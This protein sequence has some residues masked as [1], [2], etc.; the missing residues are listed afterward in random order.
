[1]IYILTGNDSKSKGSQIKLL[2]K[3]QKVI[4]LPLS[5][6]KEN[7]LIYTSFNLFNENPTIVVENVLQE[8]AF[9]FSD[10]ELQSLKESPTNFIFLEDSLNKEGEK[11]YSK[12]AE[13][14]KKFEQKNLKSTPKENLF[15]IVD[16]FAKKNKIETWVLYT[17][18]V[19]SGASP[20]AMIGMFF[21]KIKTMMLSN[22]KIF[23][24]EQL[25]NF[26]KEIVDLYH[27]AHIGNTD[28]TI[29][30]EQFI[31]KSLN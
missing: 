24:K 6:T 3:D 4:F 12:Y 29:G 7:F 22:S 15:N 27:Q 16:S 10:E 19:E 21:W 14:I 30:L 1:M 9:Q 20:E 23:S 31:L 25:K 26:S 8:N 17:K 18:A 11:K 28:I 13:N 2:A 5:C